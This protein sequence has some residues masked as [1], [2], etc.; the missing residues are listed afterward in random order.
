MGS[1]CEPALSAT[2]RSFKYQQ[3]L[4]KMAAS[5][6]GLFRVSSSPGQL[7]MSCTS[8]FI[9]LPL[10]KT[11]VGVWWLGDLTRKV[12]CIPQKVVEFWYI[13]AYKVAV[14]EVSEVL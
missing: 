4:N 14:K 1:I 8:D 6:D 12:C 3:D 11:I 5:H 2:K 13:L 10:T 9:A 7:Q